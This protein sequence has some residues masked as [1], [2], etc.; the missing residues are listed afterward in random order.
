V[1]GGRKRMRLTAS[2]ILDGRYSKPRVSLVG[3]VA[4]ES[5]RRDA[6]NRIIILFTFESVWPHERPTAVQMNDC[7]ETGSGQ[8]GLALRTD[9]S[10]LGDS[11]RSLY[12]PDSGKDRP[13]LV[14]RAYAIDA[15]ETRWRAQVFNPPSADASRR[16]RGV[17]APA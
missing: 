7:R 2:I 9:S 14:I 10:V 4:G 13:I 5:S 6:L 8:E 15:G 16:K 1:R 3:L 12:G 11:W 17:S